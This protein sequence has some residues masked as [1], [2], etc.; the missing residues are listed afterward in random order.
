MFTCQEASYSPAVKLY[1]KLIT[2]VLD[3]V[4]KL[5]S[6]GTSRYFV[7]TTTDQVS[8]NRSDKVARNYM[9]CVMRKPA[10]CT[11]DQCLCFHYIDSTIPLLSKSEISSLL[12]P[13]VSVQPSLCQT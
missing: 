12:P 6:T 3:K 1:V 5:I 4:R 7:N 8:G 13:S 2:V 10:F 9:N 11:A